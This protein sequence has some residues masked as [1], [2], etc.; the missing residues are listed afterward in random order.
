MTSGILLLDKPPG[1]SSNAALQRV[2]TLFGRVKAG[3]VGSLD[4]LATGMLPV[5]LGEATKIAGDIVAARKRYRFTIALGSSTTTG[6]SEGEVRE[7]AAVPALARAAIEA[8]LAR[9]LGPTE[10]VPPM[11]S[12][13][14]Q[15]GRPLYT[16]ARAGLTVPRAPRAIELDALPLL[17]LAEASLELEALCS[18]G[19]YIRVLAEDI[20]RVLGTCGHVVA[21]RRLYVEP[22][23]HEEM[24]TL[25]S[26]SAALPALL[27]ADRPLAHLPAVELDPL[28][29]ARL[30]RGQKVPTT[31]P[32]A[33]ARVRIYGS[34]GVFLGVG[35][36]EAGG[37]L[38]PRRLFQ[39]I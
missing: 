10:Q 3:H 35:A 30:F 38:Q 11:Y 28:A 9:F 26:L 17:A 39:G 36:V 13:L 24:H 32:G 7:R 20:A 33:H 4:P 14:K 2:R 15:G 8:V 19:T 23:E 18:K 31:L 29:T 22:F 12:A 25:E 37:L 6:D 34:D 16:L 21:L 27:P 5:C 1:L